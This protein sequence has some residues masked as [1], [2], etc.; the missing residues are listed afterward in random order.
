MIRKDKLADEIDALFQVPLAEFTGLRKSLA[1]RLKKE[2]R[3]DEAERVIEFAK[4]PIS[5]WTVNQL[6]WTHRGS[7]DRLIATGQRFRRAQTTRQSSK[8]AD[9]REALDSR[10]EVLSELSDLATGLLRDS[11]HNPSA[12]TIRRITTT[13]EALSAYES[14][15]DGLSLGRLTH[16]VDPPGFESLGAFTPGARTTARTEE[17][18]SMSSATKSGGPPAKS[19]QKAGAGEV[20][21]GK[22][23]HQAGITAAKASLQ[24]AKKSLSEARTKAQNL[25]SAL[26]KADAAAK[27][28]EKD[29][30]ELQERLRKV[31]MASE[32]AAG[33]ARGVRAELEVATKAIEER[34]R[35]VE[36]LTRKLESLFR[37]SR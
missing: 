7:F 23:A 11:G 33:R 8:V 36:D 22:E 5:T 4:P 28:T 35:T 31:T 2:G 18:V 13:L 15:P 6:Y 17:P 19:R 12:E 34:K 16:D 27:E 32:D 14:L 21:R 1:A 9:M 29:R 25:E 30:R 26:K 10:R 24:A 3:T 37:E 20:S